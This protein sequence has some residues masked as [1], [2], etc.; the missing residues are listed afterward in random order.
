MHQGDGSGVP[1]YDTDIGDNCL[2]LMPSLLHE[3]ALVTA[4]GGRACTCRQSTSVL[5]MPIHEH[6]LPLVDRQRAESWKYLLL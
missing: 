2:Y 3:T 6:M 5:D 1:A 4:I